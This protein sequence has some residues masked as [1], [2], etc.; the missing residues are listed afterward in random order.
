MIERKKIHTNILVPVPM[1]ESKRV[2]WGNIAVTWLPTPLDQLLSVGF[3]T[4]DAIPSLEDLTA[5]CIVSSKRI[6]FRHTDPHSVS[7]VTGGDVFDE[8]RRARALIAREEKRGR[9][10]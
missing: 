4:I 8:K 5:T 1:E 7:V 10:R 9:N 3:P 6:T 2:D